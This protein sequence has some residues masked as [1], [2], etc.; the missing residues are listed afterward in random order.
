MGIGSAV[1]VFSAP[2][3]AATMRDRSMLGEAGAAGLTGLLRLAAVEGFVRLFEEQSR[4]LCGM[5]ME[6][7]MVAQPDRLI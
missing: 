6:D 4:L 1:K 5:I 7:G 2:S 3:N